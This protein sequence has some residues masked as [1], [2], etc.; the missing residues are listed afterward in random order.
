MDDK[1]AVMMTVTSSLQQACKKGELQ[2]SNLAGCQ[3]ILP[4]CQRKI[5]LAI[6]H[7]IML[8]LQA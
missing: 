8:T 7:E 5:M 1:Q 2:A 6:K 3:S 4:T